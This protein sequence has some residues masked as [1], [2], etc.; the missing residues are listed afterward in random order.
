MIEELKED[1]IERYNMSWQDAHLTDELGIINLAKENFK[2]QLELLME[3]CIKKGEI[4]S[5]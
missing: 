1:L 2:R 5:L 4:N 3:L